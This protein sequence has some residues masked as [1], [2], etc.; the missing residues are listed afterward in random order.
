MHTTDC[1]E[2]FVPL[3]QEDVLQALRSTNT[4][5][6]ARQAKARLAA[7]IA[8]V[9]AQTPLAASSSQPGHPSGSIVPNQALPVH[10]PAAVLPTIQQQLPARWQDQPAV[11]DLEQ[12]LLPARQ[13]HQPAGD[14]NQP[15][16]YPT[17]P[18]WIDSGL[19]GEGLEHLLLPTRRP[20]EPAGDPHQPQL[21]PTEPDWTH[22]SSSQLQEGFEGVGQPAGLQHDFGGPVQGL[23]GPD[24]GRDEPLLSQHGTPGGYD[25]QY[26]AVAPGQ[27]QQLLRQQ[28][29]CLQR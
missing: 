5:I 13:P 15:L 28:Y 8:A 3:L 17:K 24:V 18:G 6:L 23:L 7:A 20:H 26:L 14:P 25:P 12:Q 1:S 11:E 21:Y 16:L 19:P 27:Q 4:S 22:T 9:A 29:Y 10:M 2:C